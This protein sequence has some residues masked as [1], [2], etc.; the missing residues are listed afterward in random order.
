MTTA[1]GPLSAQRLL[2]LIKTSLEDDKADDLVVIDLAGKTGIADFMAIASGR[3]QRHVAA[4]AEHI[5]ER[6]KAAAGEAPSIE[7]LAQADWVLI[8]AGDVIVHLFRPE[9]REYYALER[10]WGATAYRALKAAEARAG[11][12]A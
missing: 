11:I 5:R 12:S 4:M 8:D 10:L 7:G 3:S 2:A 6:M 9:V 1:N